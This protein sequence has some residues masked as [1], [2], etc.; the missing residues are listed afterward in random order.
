MSIFICPKCGHKDI[1]VWKSCKWL[2]YSVYAH[3]SELELWNPDL[4]KALEKE[5][6]I[7]RGP[8][9]YHMTKSKKII[10]RMLD[11]GKS[12]FQS[13]GFTEKP[14]DPFQRKLLEVTK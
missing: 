6:W 10:Y 2:R 7:K 1:P 5:S 13:H 4:T 9:W 11:M 14:K 3:V 8:Y 12:E